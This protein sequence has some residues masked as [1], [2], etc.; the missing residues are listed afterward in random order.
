MQSDFDDLGCIKY[1][2]ER[3]ALSKKLCLSVLAAVAAAVSIGASWGA[4][5]QT[6]PPQAAVVEAPQ[7][8]HPVL[9]RK[10]AVLRFTNI[11][12]Y[13]KS[14]LADADD[15]PLAQQASDMLTARLVSTGK[16]LVFER[17]ATE[18]L[19]REMAASGGKSTGVT[20]VDAVVIGSITEFGR[21][22]DGEAGFL[23]SSMRQ[24]ASA[25]VEVR[26]VD[27]KTGQAF[28]S[29][30]GTGVATTTAKEVAG[31]GSRA[32][33]DATLND[34]AISAAISDLI[35]NVVAKLEER[36]WS[37]DVLQLRAGGVVMISGGPTQGLWVGQHLSLE[38]RG[39]TLISGQNGLP[40]TLPGEKLGEIEVQSFFGDQPEAEG[41]VA[42]IV[43]GAADGRAVKDLIVKEIRP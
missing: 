18:A 11:S 29:G 30:K 32:G 40:I 24:S 17:S 25:T 36:R 13:G 4:R 1:L 6:A 39:E 5:A 37:S 22:V 42:R 31:F 26:L 3:S 19:Q 14:L 28:F 33:Y 38:T 34:K 15:D 23:N 41:A 9:K 21:K 35:N 12:R 16:F 27:V 43:Q 7:Q 8:A 10:I 20:G 2:Y